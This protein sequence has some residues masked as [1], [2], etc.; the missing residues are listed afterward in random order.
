MVLLESQNVKLGSELKKF[1]LPNVGGGDF[2][3]DKLGKDIVTIA[4]ICNHCPYV[5][6][7]IDD[8]SS[9]AAKNANDINVVAI[10]SNDPDYTEEDS[11]TNMKNFSKKHNFSFP[12]LFDETQKTAKDFGAV[13]TPDIF[14]YKKFTDSNNAISS[15]K[16]VYHGRFEDLDQ[17]FK[18]LKNS[19][20]ISLQQLPSIGC[21]IKW[22][23]A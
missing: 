15:Y 22:K 5:Q 2:S 21:S 23:S 4:F 6:K 13:C 16:L 7:I 10:S 3:S 19:N 9:L 18:E 11:F 20:S 8:F 12:Y 1:N 17:V 14:V